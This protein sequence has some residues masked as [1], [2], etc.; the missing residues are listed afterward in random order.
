LNQKIKEIIYKKGCGGVART[1]YEDVC[2]RDMY[3]RA[4]VVTVVY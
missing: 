1:V 2:E 4:S 3:A